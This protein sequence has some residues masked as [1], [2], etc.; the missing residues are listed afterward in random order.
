MP[1]GFGDKAGWFSFAHVH[2]A[3]ALRF[4]PGCGGGARKGY[5]GR[6]ADVPGRF[7]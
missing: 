3:E 7:S 4:A 1:P 6:L 5:A 2:A